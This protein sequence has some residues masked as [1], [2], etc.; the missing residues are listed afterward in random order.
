MLGSPPR[1]RE[2]PGIIS[3]RALLLGI[4]P[5]YAGKTHAQSSYLS[6]SQDHPR[7]CGKDSAAYNQRMYQM[8]SPPRM[9]ERHFKAILPFYDSGITPAYAG[10]TRTTVA[11]LTLTRDHP[12]VCGKD[13]HTNA[14]LCVFAGSPPRMRERRRINFQHI[15]LHRITPAY[16]GKTQYAY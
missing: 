1:M 12:R 6:G 8:G 15:N 13:S 11:I 14:P 3:V 10:K 16:A 5:A 7:V 4:T 2:I 9:R